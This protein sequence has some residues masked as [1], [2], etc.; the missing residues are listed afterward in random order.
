MSNPFIKPDEPKE[1]SE[2]N[3]VPLA[4]VSLVLLII[5]LVLSPMMAQS[6]LHVQTAARDSN[7]L[8]PELAPV[9]FPRPP[10]LVLVVALGPEGLAIGEQ[11]FAG[12]GELMGFLK[13]ELSRR[14]DKK[15]FLA[16]HLDTPHGLVVNTVETIKGCGAEAVALVQAQDENDGQIQPA[17]TAP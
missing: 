9:L 10:E 11:R 15:V 12:P 4:D 2:V 8:P 6:M 13:D 16:P 17:T 1:I 7:P 14:A 5:L 3:V